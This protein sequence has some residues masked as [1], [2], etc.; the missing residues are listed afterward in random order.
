[1]IFDPYA[2]L[3]IGRDADLN[4]IKKAH[5]TKV[6]QHHPDKDGDRNEFEEV[7]RA[8][9]LLID[10]ERRTRFDATGIDTDDGPAENAEGR[11]IAM[12][13]ACLNALL[14]DG[15]QKGIDLASLDLVKQL[16]E[17][18]KLSTIN[19]RV[20]QD[21]PKRLAAQLDKIVARMRKKQAIASP[22]VLA[23]MKHQA[24]EHRERVRLIEVEIK[25][26]DR[27]LAILGDYS[28]DVE[29]MMEASYPTTATGFFHMGG[30]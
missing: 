20:Q 25:V 13:M 7:S 26:L 21:R 30:F 14:E 5:R 2:V 12:I 19:A 24:D 17:N 16:T 1:M 8:V 9:A 29:R 27:A 4:D 23:A 18:L 10:P 22:L 6:K 11:A 3:G 28:F 15:L